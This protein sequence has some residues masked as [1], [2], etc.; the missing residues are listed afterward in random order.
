MRMTAGALVVLAA[1]A[2]LVIAL[3]ADPRSIDVLFE[4]PCTNPGPPCLKSVEG[5]NARVLAGLG[6]A[7][8][9]GYG[10]VAL[11]RSGGEAPQL[12]RPGAR[13]RPVRRNPI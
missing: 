11:L 7:L 2:G 8:A 9:A 10:I 5:S 4:L 3:R 12:P 6:A 1:A 13:H